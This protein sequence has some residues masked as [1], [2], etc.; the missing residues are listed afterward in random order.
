MD[1]RNVNDRTSIGYCFK[2][3]IRA[4]SWNNKKENTIVLSNTKVECMTTTHSERINLGE[5]QAHS[6]IIYCDS[7]NSI[8]FTLD[9]EFHACNTFQTH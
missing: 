2:L 1:R 5:A 8:L 7:Q 3:L 6:K 9:L 4:I